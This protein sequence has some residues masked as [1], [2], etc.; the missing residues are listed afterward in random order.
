MRTLTVFGLL[1]L[2]YAAPAATISTTSS[3][4][5]G[6]INGGPH[7]VDIVLSD[8]RI[9]TGN[10]FVSLNNLAHTWP[11]DLV[12][13]VTH[14][15]T[16]TTATLF[17]R[18]GLPQSTFGCATDFSLGNYTFSDSGSG[19]LPCPPNPIPAGTYRASRPDDT[20][21]FIANTFNGLAATGTWRLSI[22]DFFPGG[23]SGSL[24][25]W[26]LNLDVA[27]AEVPEPGTLASVAL[28][29]AAAAL[30]RR[31]TQMRS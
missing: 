30:W 25:N 8:P 1:A 13:T 4:G 3:G 31:R 6:L 7:T 24:V 9:I 28:G 15:E 20:A 16:G 23:D 14:V 5:I 29:L 26:T 27:D 2:A 22:T 18:I 11:G 17:D 19:P 10:F 21:V 12:V